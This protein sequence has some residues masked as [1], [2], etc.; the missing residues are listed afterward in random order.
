[1]NIGN[2]ITRSIVSEANSNNL[3]DGAANMK[4]RIL[5]VFFRLAC[6]VIFCFAQISLAAWQ[7]EGKIKTQFFE[8]ASE[9][10]YCWL[11]TTDVRFRHDGADNYASVFNGLSSI[12]I[13]LATDDKGP[14]DVTVMF[15]GN[16]GSEN[17]LASI[18]EISRTLKNK[19]D[20][21]VVEQFGEIPPT[22]TLTFRYSRLESGRYLL[23]LTRL[24]LYELVLAVATHFHLPRD[25]MWQFADA[26]GV[27]DWIEAT[28]RRAVLDS[29][30]ADDEHLFE[31]AD[32]EAAK[33]NL[34][35]AAV[36]AAPIGA[37]AGAGV[38]AGIG[39][40]AAAGGAGVGA[41]VGV[42]AGAGVGAGVGI[43]TSSSTE[44]GQ[45]ASEPVS[46]EGAFGAAP[47]EP[48]DTRPSEPGWN[49]RLGDNGVWV[50][51]DT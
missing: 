6:V 36:S 47:P 34:S 5:E 39:A 12:S 37:G 16:L 33:H 25:T 1:L 42:G 20:V 15:F 30:F 8:V 22:L 18:S 3:F 49:M 38:G 43:V 32:K 23:H 24:Y 14:T 10:L 31:A 51:M 44:E 29:K 46:G 40:S 45:R 11:P 26:L 48:V 9:P 21:K 2:L 41:G 27:K 7:Q 17:F 35:I 4:R 13:F 50:Q 28:H 19:E